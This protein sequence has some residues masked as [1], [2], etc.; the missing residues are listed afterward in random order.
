MAKAP[1]PG[2]MLVL[3]A[4]SGAGK[5][6]LARRLVE[7]LPDAVFS[8][9]YTTRPPRPGE[10]DGVDYHFV[11]RE[12][13]DG[14]VARG[15]FLEWAE[16]H[17]NHYGSAWEAVRKDLAAGRIVVFDI[18][19]QGGEQIAAKHPDAV[20]VLIVP[21]SFEELER[22]LRGRRTED[23]EALARRLAAAE[24]EIA[25]ALESYGY[26]VVNDELDHAQAALEAI[27]QAE[28]H[29]LPRL[30]AREGSYDPS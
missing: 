7:C 18:D 6:T 25:R 3:S 15:A 24:A 2:L 26:L 8:I 16:V 9:S 4:P 28:R 30:L 17:G 27:L 21:P 29:R 11:D 10:R 14:M 12:T 22:R 20:T 23:E 5:T 13:F 19:V 1:P